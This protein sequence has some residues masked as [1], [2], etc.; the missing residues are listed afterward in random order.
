MSST[1]SPSPV[2]YHHLYHIDTFYPTEG[3]EREKIRVTR[4]E[5][6]GNVVECIRKIKLGDLN[7]YS[8]KRNADWRVSVNLEVPGELP[9]HFYTLKG[10]SMNALRFQRTASRRVVHN[11]AQ[12]GQ[13]ELH[14]RGVH[15][16]SHAS[17]K[18]RVKWSRTCFLFSQSASP[19]FFQSEVLHE[20][21]LEFTRS[22]LL[23]ATANRRGDPHSS[24][25]ERAAFDE[26]IRAFVNNAR[27]L[28]RNSTDSWH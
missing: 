20:L 12:K 21:E 10:R 26:L 8:P 22:E 7:I 23:L 6:S 4:D 24:E 13:T 9:L 11:D 17:D 27:I 3:R 2:D 1:S 15:H 19:N 25:L 5:K 16:R 18:V 28:V 14:T